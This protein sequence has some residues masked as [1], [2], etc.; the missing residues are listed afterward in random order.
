MNIEKIELIIARYLS[1]QYAIKDLQIQLSFALFQS[2]QM[3]QISLYKYAFPRYLHSLYCKL[4]EYY[5][6]LSK[7]EEIYVVCYISCNQFWSWN[8][9][10]DENAME[11]TN[12]RKS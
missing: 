3:P 6:T 5:L 7:W 8:V 12:Y 1:M 9:A 2:N 10:A 4:D 11:T